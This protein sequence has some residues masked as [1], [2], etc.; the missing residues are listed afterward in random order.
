MLKIPNLDDK[1]DTINSPWVRPYPLFI[2]LYFFWCYLDCWCCT[3][4]ETKRILWQSEELALRAFNRCDPDVQGIVH[5]SFGSFYF[6]Y[7]SCVV[8]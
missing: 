7:L 3:R 8:W 6:T 5:L 4:V 2:W 1:L